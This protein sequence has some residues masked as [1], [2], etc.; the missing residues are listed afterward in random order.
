MKSKHT[1]HR[2]LQFS[3]RARAYAG[4]IQHNIVALAKAVKHN[5]VIGSSRQ[6]VPLPKLYASSQFALKGFIKD[7]GHQGVE[8]GG[9]FRLQ[10][11]QRRHLPR[12]PVQIP[13]DPPLLILATI[14]RE[15]CHPPALSKVQGV[16]QGQ[17]TLASI[18][19]QCRPSA[20]RSHRKCRQI[21]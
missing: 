10:P 18:H 21:S 2:F 11:R 15:C 19:P 8:G 9:G 4:L 12:Q 17:S 7:G 13:H 3:L 14:R 20:C 16:S 6:T 1:P 5:W